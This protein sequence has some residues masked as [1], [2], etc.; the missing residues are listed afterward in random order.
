MI[1]KKSNSFSTPAKAS[2]E[3]KLSAKA[4]HL[5]YAI[6]H[7][8]NFR[9][10]VIQLAGDVEPPMWDFLDAAVQEMRKESRKGITVKINSYGG[11]TYE[12]LAIIGTLRSC[13]CYI[14]TEGYGPVM[15]AAALILAS[16]HKRRISEYAWFMWHEISYSGAGTHKQMKDLIFQTEREQDQWARMMAQFSNEDAKFWRAIAENK[17]AYF[18]PEEL[19]NAGVADESF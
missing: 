12:A 14:T 17:D 5:D 9:D 6:S 18:N 8:I 7:G 10:R 4:L 19:I 11:S 15:S 13:G 1:K 2:V 16:G 3:A